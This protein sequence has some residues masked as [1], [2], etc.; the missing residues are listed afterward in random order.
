[1]DKNNDESD[2]MIRI[3]NY[4]S[5]FQKAEKDVERRRTQW[6]TS[7]KAFVYNTLQEVVER[8]PQL[9][10]HVN[11]NNTI[12]NMES[13]F[14]RFDHRP[15]GI[16]KVEYDESGKPVNF[17]SFVKR[18]GSLC[19]SQMADGF[20]LAWF[21]RS[22]IENITFWKPEDLEARIDE[23]RPSEVSREV[24]F[25]HVYRFL[26]EMVEGEAPKPQS[27]K[28]GFEIDTEEEK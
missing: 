2:L 19:Y 14:L 18:G 8:Y 26:Y 1:M 10:W 16:E 20:I 4:V 21:T 5:I 24:I 7:V 13:V 12:K 23:Y 17:T 15:S 3:D 6:Q 22:Y 28:V 27:N 9:Q 11:S 25:E